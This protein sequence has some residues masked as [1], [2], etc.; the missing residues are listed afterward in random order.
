MKTRVGKIA[1]LP[2]TIREQL[3]QRLADGESGKRV[4]RWLNEL[5]E[6]Q[7]IM[8]EQFA[9]QP[10][11]EQN[12]SEW[13]KGGLVDWLR[14]QEL[15]LRARLVVEQSDEL[16][17]DEGSVDLS[18]SLAFLVVGELMRQTQA[19]EE[20][21]NANE[22]WRKLREISRELSRIRR[23]D[24]RFRRT[25]LSRDKWESTLEPLEEEPN[26]ELATQNPESETEPTA[27][28]ENPE[29][30]AESG[31]EPETQN[32]ESENY[33]SAIIDT[34]YPTINPPPDH[35]TQSGIR[36]DPT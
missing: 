33:Y 23:D 8:A 3:N 11:R 27:E 6:V 5:P 22:R 19:L 13:R 10:V 20:V 29:L 1:R 34:K 18:E 36:P 14:H 16:G 15:R 30:E 4:V 21:K 12:I 17:E 35:E 32:S 28:P 24:Q 26:P 9:G 25:E 7:K 31:V 2:H